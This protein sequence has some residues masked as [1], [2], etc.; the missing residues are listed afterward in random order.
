MSNALVAVGL[1]VDLLTAAAELTAKLQVVSGTLQKA[2]AEGRDLT[3]Q[4]LGDIR[5]LD[6]AA[7]ERLEKLLA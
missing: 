1:A 7:R 4:E 6:D 2:R 3:D 5:S